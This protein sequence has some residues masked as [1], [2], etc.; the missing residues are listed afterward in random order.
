MKN[1]YI[2]HRK[3][4]NIVFSFIISFLLMSFIFIFNKMNG[5][6]FL[7]LRSDN[8][9]TVGFYRDLVNNLLT[10]NSIFFNFSTGLGLNNIMALS[11]LLSPFNIL[12]LIFH[13]ADF[14]LV[15][16]IIIVL[17]V[18]FS[19]L[20]FQVFSHKVL[21]NE[22][23][24]SILISVFY[25]INAFV[26]GYGTIILCWLDAVIILPLL[27]TA[28]V[29]CI[30]DNKRLGLIFLYMYLFVAH[31]YPGYVVGIF[32]LLFVILYI[33]FIYRFKNSRIKEILSK[34]FNWFLSAFIGILLAAWLWVPTLFFIM[35]N[36]V[37]DS[38]E[39]IQLNVSLLQIL[40]SLFW[41]MSYGIE[42]TYSYIYCGIPVIILASLFFINKKIDKNIKWFFGIL[43]FILLISM[44]S[45]KM[46][47]IWHVFDQPDD[48]WYRYS[49]LLCFCLCS[50]A[51]LEINNLEPEKLINKLIF[52]VIG[53]SMFYQLMLHTSSLWELESGVL[54]TNYG[55]IVN[56]MLLICWSAVIYFCI[57]KSAK[58]VLFIVLST[59]LL[60]FESLSNS[61]RILLDLTNAEDYNFWINSVEKTVNQIK[62]SDSDFYRIII[63]NN[64][65]GYNMDT[66]FSYNGIGDF[67]NQEK[68]GV[69]RFLSNIG[70]STSP[71]VV[72][73]NG[74]NPV[75]EMLLGVRYE[76]F[77]PE[78]NFRND[79]K[80]ESELFEENETQ[81]SETKTA[82]ETKSISLESSYIKNDYALNLGYLVKGDLLLYD[83]SG[84]NVF[85][86][87][88]DIVSTM[89]GID[90]DC[91]IEVS[92]EDIKFDSENMQLSE[93]DNGD[94]V[95]TRNDSQSEMEI[96]VD[97]DKYKDAYIQ[98]EKSE[99]GL[100]GTDFYI[101]DGQNSPNLVSDRFGVSY[102]VKMAEDSENNRYKIT[103][104]SYE[105]YSPEI[106]VC[107]N[108]NVYYLDEDVLKKH[109]EVLS[110]N[111]FMVSEYNNGHVAGT[112][113]IEGDRRTL[114]TTIPYDPGW[115]VSIN[116]TDTEPIRLIDGVFMGVLFPK[117]GD[118]VVVFDYECPGLK[119]GIILS[120]CGVLATLSVAFEKKLKKK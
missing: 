120:L 96:S 9:D 107:D 40:N 1:L 8:L 17:K 7:V 12:Y 109:Y 83:Y 85:E 86:N 101:F 47:L 25:S 115:S 62:T 103:V 44:V 108:I 27:C 79:I 2:K 73:E 30:E 91:Y 64:N 56:L 75:S 46:N 90:E 74:Y 43:I 45:N 10:N 119:I 106:N 67:G 95:F 13:N 42:G 72:S 98:F 100:Y 51:S 84:R 111:Q 70:F 89:S 48:F 113:H 102:A 110:Q 118:F 52:I 6:D 24:F 57:A 116:G 112:V 55:F 29:S 117:D 34:F 37:P 66:Y 5:K 32:S 23:I 26:L 94:F 77:S 38:T 65:S 92:K 28:I 97:K 82:E 39:V 11:S 53:L 80:D 61:K 19:G 68:Y 4:L 14:D 60:I 22:K 87:M 49:Y 58:V 99:P 33:L 16:G 104:A 105:G 41:G 78:I 88:N 18:G 21:K 15:T 59:I 3:L 81:E 54:N 35:S 20:A 76:I 63:A 36:R 50:I 31:F 69:R 114:F 93:M 71:R